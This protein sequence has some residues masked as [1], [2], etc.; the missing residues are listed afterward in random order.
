MP[1]DDGHSPDY[2]CMSSGC[3]EP[4]TGIA[5]L[6]ITVSGTLHSDG[7][8]G[9]PVGGASVFVTDGTGK[10][11]HLVSSATGIFWSGV[12]D[13]GYQL[14]AGPQGTCAGGSCT[15]FVA[16]GALQSIVTSLCPSTPK[17]C[18]TPLHGQC[19]A[20]HTVGSGSQQS[21]HP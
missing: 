16:E 14:S 21:V 5:G 8:G 17:T 4:A 10:T 1:S 6:T 11:L 2:D 3:H 13:G 20:C 19:A 18:T 12:S 9:A 7:H 15:Q